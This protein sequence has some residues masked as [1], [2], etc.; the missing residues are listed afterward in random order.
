MGTIGRLTKAALAAACLVTAAGVAPASGSGAG[1]RHAASTVQAV[2]T[3]QVR[4]VYRPFTGDFD[5][6]HFTDVFWYDP[7]AGGDPVWLNLGSQ[8]TALTQHVSGTF[9]PVVGDF[10]GDGKDDI[11]WYAPGPAT[12]HLWVSVGHGRFSPRSVSMDSTAQAIVGR[13]AGTDQRDDIFWFSGKAGGQDTVWRGEPGGTF[14]KVWAGPT[15]VGALAAAGTFRDAGTNILFYVPGPGADT[16]AVFPASG[17][18]IPAFVAYAQPGRYTPIVGDFFTTL[19]VSG[20]CGTDGDT[21]FTSD[22]ES[23]S[24]IYWYG[25]GTAP[26]TAWAFSGKGDGTYGTRPLAVNASYRPVLVPI[27]TWTN[28][29]PGSSNEGRMDDDRDSVQWYSAGFGKVVG[30]DGTRSVPVNAIPLVGQVREDSEFNLGSTV[31]G[32]YWYVPGPGAD[33]YEELP[34]PNA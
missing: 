5:G 1:H 15:H 28:A 25:P 30:P 32:I 20:G 18:G 11:F 6:D 10:T 17:S 21:A 14:T 2:R 8:R 29:C 33:L 12:D 31:V 27:S 22:G 4:G 3:T 23:R 19:T 16:M 24:D 34:L 26:D 9:T 7:S 13:F